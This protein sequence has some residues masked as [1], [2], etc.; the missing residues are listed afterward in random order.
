MRY[1]VKAWMAAG[2]L[3]ML[4]GCAG[5]LPWGPFPAQ[6]SSSAS[7]AS[8][9]APAPAAPAEATLKSSDAVAARTPAPA[10]VRAN[11]GTQWGEGIASSVSTVNLS[12]VAPDA[13]DAQIAIYY[14]D[15]SGT[16]AATRGTT[17]PITTLPLANGRIEFS[18]HGERGQKLA[19]HYRDRAQELYLA[20]RDGDR[21]QLRFANRSS[22]TTYEIVATVDGLDVI[23]G[24]PGSLSNRGYVLYPGRVLTIEGFRKSDKEVA[25]FRFSAPGDAYA[26]NTAAGHPRNIGVIGLAAFTLNEPG[27]ENATPPRRPQPFPADVPAA[28]PR[29]APP[30]QYRN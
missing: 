4:A 14:N 8:F 28:D 29:Y 17:R 23:S 18:V 1:N 7:P 22:G 21:Y 15:L 10:E 3:A 27:R 9:P 20:G 6:S 30:P 19:L 5:Q 2:L 11:L 12:R 25:A 16:R 13:P 24:E 26:A